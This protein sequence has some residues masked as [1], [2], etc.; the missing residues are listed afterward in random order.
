[1]EVNIKSDKFERINQVRWFI[2]SSFTALF[3]IEGSCYSS[4]QTN[5]NTSLREHLSECEQPRQYLSQWA[6]NN[7]TKRYD[8]IFP[9]IWGF[10]KNSDFIFLFEDES[11]AMLFFLTFK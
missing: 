2:T 5:N 4:D 6:Q 10:K 9:E 3:R 8:I 7:L 11:D 1:M